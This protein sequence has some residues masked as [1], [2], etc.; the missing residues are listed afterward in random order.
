MMIKRYGAVG[1]ACLMLASIA[2]GAEP[3]DENQSAG[4]AIVQRAVELRGDAQLLLFDIGAFDPIQETP[5]APAAMRVS[6]A[7]SSELQVAQ[8][9]HAP[10]AKDIEAL[11]TSGWEVLEAIPNNAYGVRRLRQ[12]A[13]DLAGLP[14]VRYAGPYRG[15]YKLA[16]ALAD[17]AERKAGEEIEVVVTLWPG[18]APRQAS[19]ALEESGASEMKIPRSGYYPRVICKMNAS[20]I[21]AA[22]GLDSVRRIEPYLAVE[23]RNNSA[24]GILQSGVDG[25]RSIWG[26]GLHGEGQVIGHIDDAIDLD[27]CFFR[28]NSNNTPRPSHRKVVAYHTSELPGDHG[29]H[30]AGTA[31]GLNVNG[32]IDNAGHAYNAKLT[33]TS[34]S[35]VDLAV[36]LPRAQSEGA[37]IH[38]NSWGS[39]DSRAYNY[40]CVD[41]DQYSWANENGLVL[42]A[43]TNLDELTHVPENAKNCLG[44]GNA[45]HAPNHMNRTP[46]G[47]GFGPTTDGRRK[48]E[49]FAPG[50]DTL[51]ALNGSS[52]GTVEYTGTSMATP[53]L[54]GSTALIRQYFVEGFYPT[55]NAQA[56]DALIPSGPLM[57]AMLLNSTVDMTGVTGYPSY[58]EGWGLPKLDNALYF[59]GDTRRLWAHDE[60]RADGVGIAQGE[61]DAY[62]VSVINASEPL[63]VTLVWH[64]PPGALNSSAPVVNNLNLIVIEPDLTT[65]YLGNVLS[66]G[67]STTG[68]SQDVLNNV[69]M[70]L[71]NTPS[72]GDYVV[73]VDGTTVNALYGN[74]GYAVVATGGLAYPS[75]GSISLDA[76]RYDCASLVTLT[77]LDGNATGGSVSATLTTLSGD[78][79][80][81]T[82]TGSATSG[83]TGSIP[84]LSSSVSA[85]NGV[86]EGSSGQLFTATYYDA[87]TGGAP[88]TANVSA[89]AMLDCLPP[90]IEEV[91]ILEI[92]NSSAS[93]FFRADEEVFGTAE[94][95]TVCG[96]PSFSFAISQFSGQTYVAYLTG[97]EPQEHYYVYLEVEDSLSHPLTD[98]N[99]GACYHF[100]TGVETLVSLYD[101]EPGTD[102]FTTIQ[103]SGTGGWVWTSTGYVHS[104]SHSFYCQ[105]YDSVNDLSL[106]SVPIVVPSAHPMLKFWHTYSFESDIFGDYDGGV[107]EISTNGGSSWTDLGDAIVSGGYTGVLSD[108]YD[109]PLGGRQAWTDGDLGTLTEATVDLQEYAGESVLIRW[110]FGSDSSF[111]DD[112]WYVDD[113]SIVSQTPGMTFKEH[114]VTMS[115]DWS[116][117]K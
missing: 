39:D 28:D 47:C 46:W 40:W 89:T 75:K 22:L 49:I 63:K 106:R 109:N 92:D 112:G 26:Y 71:L 9:D 19:I 73:R 62:T 35:S 11:R 6:R 33:H 37:Y 34:S 107:L 50:T 58:E 14:G 42:F 48:P 61:S 117:L 99:G 1:M 98:D 45:D 65:F 110:R 56:S 30:T 7:A 53:A 83:F 114:P 102:G 100:V 24:T 3:G 44:V 78:S 51:S 74:Q 81:V 104:A 4:E 80:A 97:L 76:S 59:T 66:G 86:L 105:D 115:R 16:R 38:T 87:N 27:S 2:T 60:R 96:A 15:E 57:K 116:I 23:L 52:C 5:S 29:T 67:Q 85:G 88:V 69:E 95:G 17:S 68:G 101:F 82:L 108:Y 94:A 10:V 20:E 43:A 41:I 21:G 54:A 84:I 32:D 70:V 55:G 64:D 79:E 91:T 25:V 72:V 103:T 31:A 18:A 12:D 113:V 8:F 111:G 77:V 90:V 93:I 36:V 13:A